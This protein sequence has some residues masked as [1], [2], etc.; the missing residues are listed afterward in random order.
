MISPNR[1][2][3]LL[4]QD[5]EIMSITGM[6]EAEYRKFVQDCQANSK[7]R[8]GEP[9]ALTGLSLFLVNLA[10]G[11]LL[12]GAS[13]LLAPKPKTEDD[14]PEVEDST[15]EGQD[16]VRRDRF[17]AKSGFDS[18]QNV[19]DLGSIVPIIYA[20]RGKNYGGVRINSNMVWSQMLSIGGGQF[21][22]GL[23]LV[24]EG[25]S[26]LKLDLQQTAFGNNTL[27]SYDLEQNIEAGRITIYEKTNGGRIKRGDYAA[28]VIAKN[29]IGASNNDVYS[30]NG[31][32]D[33]CEVV[34][35]S[36]QKEFGVYGLIGNNFG[37]K[38]G[39]DWEP[40]SQ[41]QQRA[42]T[43]FERQQSNE[44]I[45][46][47][48]LQGVCW[49]T[50]AGFVTP[51]G[52]LTP[53]VELKSFSKNDE[54]TYKIYKS[55]QDVVFTESGATAGGEP[56]SEVENIAVQTAI[57]S[58]QRIYDENINIGDVYKFGTTTCICVDRSA[59]PFISNVD[60]D[61]KGISVT[62]K[63][64]VIEP[65]KAHIW[66]EVIVED[67]KDNYEAYNSV[68][69]GLRE[70]GVTGVIASEYSHAFKLAVAAFSVERPAHTVEVGLRSNLQLR[71][72]GIPNFNSLV[73][74]D[75]GWD[76]AGNR[77]P[78]TSYQAFVDSEFCGGMKDGEDT[79]SNTYRKRIEAGDYFASDVRYSFFR[80]LIREIGQENFVPTT[81]LYGTRS[82]TGVDV[83]N[84]IRFKFINSLRREFRFVPITAWEIRSGEAT[85]DLYVLD[86][87]VESS[88][89]VTDGSIHIEGNGEKLDRAQGTFEVKA[90]KAPD[91]QLGMAV[92]DDLQNENYVD[93]WARLSEAFIYDS[94]TASS[95]GNPEHSISYVNLITTNE[96]RPRY[97][98][99]AMVGVNIN[100]T[101]EIRSLNQLSFYVTRGVI[102]SSLFP[103]VLEDLLTN[104]RYGVGG[105]FAQQQID[106]ESF[107]EAAEWT[108]SLG[109]AFDGAVSSRINI[110]S[111]ASQ[112]AQDFLLDLSVSSGRFTLK[113]AMTF[114]VAEPIAAL[115]TSGNIIEESFGMTYLP[116]QDRTDPIVSVKWREERAQ[117]L[118]EVRGLFPVIR[119]FTVRMRGVPDSAPVIQLDLSNFC[120]N[121][122]Q[123]AD[124]AYFECLQRRYVT[125]AVRFKTT[126][127]EATL[128][129][130]SII[131][132]GL[133]TVSY[134]QPLNGAITQKGFITSW[135]PLENGTHEVLIWNGKDLT[136]STIEVSN[137]KTNTFRGCVFCLRNTR[138]T[139]ETYKVQTVTFDE[140]GNID[141]E[142]I[143]WPTDEAGVSVIANGFNDN[144]F[145]VGGLP[146]SDLPPFVGP[147]VPPSPSPGPAPGPLPDP[148]P[149]P[150]PT[151]TPDPGPTPEPDPTPWFP[152]DTYRDNPPT[153]DV[154]PWI[155]ELPPNAANISKIIY[156]FG[157]RRKVTNRYKC[158][159]CFDGDPA[160]TPYPDQY[161][162]IDDQY[163][164]T[165][166]PSMQYGTAAEAI[167]TFFFEQK[168]VERYHI[169]CPPVDN[170]VT[171]YDQAEVQPLGDIFNGETNK[172]FTFTKGNTIPSGFYPQCGSNE[173]FYDWAVPQSVTY[174][175]SD[176]TPDVSKNYEPYSVTTFTSE[177]A[178]G[179][180]PEDCEDCKPD[181]DLI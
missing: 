60:T 93:G 49:T 46:N 54:I 136:E 159:Q 175:Y 173:E 87:H 181:P 48:Q 91:G 134:E 47:R 128:A 75:T 73:T 99:L 144:N 76:T 118:G 6:S 59:E 94:V 133:E 104:D 102:N 147:P 71:S 43:T 169:N 83:Y 40:L 53:D 3:V 164:T 36:N 114:W 2:F 90:F 27:A 107:Q 109:Y 178:S 64:R 108:Q 57:A 45:A 174:E 8:P 14:R 85:G 23:F 146:P 160:G 101:R 82:A 42:D 123:A 115:F 77:V 26:K 1:P 119:E 141:V 171:S 132:V 5:R 130:G 155:P 39:E 50:R 145:E 52:E 179:D 151:P 143:N 112:R 95:A 97:D 70:Y 78:D 11:L 81:D 142:A 89:S 22:K 120:T 88:F 158:L 80:V 30:I 67:E 92:I 62:A 125:H 51:A 4:P 149:P 34:L 157:W 154:P 10:V 124:R 117:G 12:T 61:D 16:V 122:R 121:V 127:A 103:D 55:V 98:N 163:T 139:T 165:W 29:D 21:F 100:S 69:K 137:G 58:K 32:T 38:I 65:G 25:S 68:P 131:K 17:T 35:P 156:E 37:Y 140:D 96:E 116:I 167:S 172:K 33:F 152:P 44:A 24:G 166:T 129:A 110:R 162:Y 20:N 111:W 161:D 135:P 153:G 18:V 138:Q 180:P 15:V 66:S 56:A 113:P 13:Y 9:V 72:S 105:V 79:S 170:T 126:P 148:F 177:G 168:K 74:Q 28:G 106:R 84:Y 41:W 150:T 19:V 176:G 31:D 63:F 86:P 7:L